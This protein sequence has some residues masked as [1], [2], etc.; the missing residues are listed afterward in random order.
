M[1]R[2][3]NPGST[4]GWLNKVVGQRLAQTLHAG[5]NMRSWI[6]AVLLLAGCG[7]DVREQIRQA[8]YCTVASD[9]GD[10][11]GACPYGCNVVVNTSEVA[12]I[13]ALLQSHGDDGCVYDCRQLRSVSCDNQVCVANY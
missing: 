8:N 6:L 7:T 5:S 9:C 11:G 4:S 12:R 13:R 2:H 3:E 10:A 1:S